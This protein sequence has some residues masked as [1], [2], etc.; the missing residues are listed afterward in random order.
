MTLRSLNK[1]TGKHVL[2][3]EKRNF[4]ASQRI[5]KYFIAKRKHLLI[6]VC[7]CHTL[8]NF[9]VFLYIYFHKSCKTQFHVKIFCVKLF[10]LS[11]SSSLAVLK[12]CGAF[13]IVL[14]TFFT[15][16]LTALSFCDRWLVPLP[17]CDSTMVGKA[18]LLL[19]LRFN[20][21]RRNERDNERDSG[22]NFF[23]VDDPDERGDDSATFFSNSE[24]TNLSRSAKS[25]AFCGSCALLLEDDDAIVCPRTSDSCF[26]KKY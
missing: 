26:S 2:E 4:V 14:M 22:L 5:L 7:N 13:L 19:L 10:L 12:R 17:L 6:H 21:P 11:S 3:N 16:G 9:F 18:E 20:D 25:T 23:N 1:Y 24:V 8:H 15:L